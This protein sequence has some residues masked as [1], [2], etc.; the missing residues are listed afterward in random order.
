MKT[1]FQ[2]DGRYTSD[3][4]HLLG[5]ISK[6]I[7]PIIKGYAKNGYSIRE[8]SHVAQAVITDFEAEFILTGQVEKQKLNRIKAKKRHA[9]DLGT[10]ATDPSWIHL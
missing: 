10:I 5:E 9:I 4:I 6:V 1:L 8:L 3:A 7:N 2:E